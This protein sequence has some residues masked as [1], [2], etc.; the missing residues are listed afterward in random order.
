MFWLLAG[1]G[2]RMFD[3]SAAVGVWR[4]WVPASGL[5]AKVRPVSVGCLGV[6]LTMFA[7]CLSIKPMMS[8]YFTLKAVSKVARMVTKYPLG[9]V[10]YMLVSA[11][12]VI[13]SVL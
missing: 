12:F 13:V 4:I 8:P 11:L 3:V 1:T 5:M 10:K 9:T 7:D 6:R 2:E